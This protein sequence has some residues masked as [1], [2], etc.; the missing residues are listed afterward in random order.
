MHR[1]HR[2]R[3]VFALPCSLPPNLA[4]RIFPDLQLPCKSQGQ[5]KAGTL[6]Q[7]YCCCCCCR[8]SNNIIQ[9]SPLSVVPLSRSRR[10]VNSEYLS[11]H[12]SS[13]ISPPRR[14]T[15]QVEI[16]ARGKEY[17]T[18][19]DTFHRFNSSPKPSGIHLRV[20]KLMVPKS[21]CS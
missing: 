18:K 7:G 4:A 3:I 5:G 21:S 8:G 16:R 19:P 13:A 9:R 10:V 14:V 1:A 15:K 6:W 2:A 20:C 11:N 17:M 12:S